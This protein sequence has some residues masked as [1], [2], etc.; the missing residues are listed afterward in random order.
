VATLDLVDLDIRFERSGRGHKAVVV[1][2]PMGDGLEVPFRRPINDQDLELFILRMSR[3]DA[4]RRTL[5]LPPAARAKELG[6]RLF[7]A[8]FHDDLLVCLRD[9]L[10]ETAREDRG[11]RIR[12]RLGAT[13]E[14]S[15]LPWEYL[16]DR[17]SNRF[18]CLSDRTPVV[19]Y[20]EVLEPVRPLLVE[21]PLRVLV[22]V[23]S[24]ND[25]PALDV[26]QEWANVKEALRELEGAERIQ[27]ERLPDATLGTLRRQLRRGSYQALHFIGHGGFDDIRG[28]GVLVLTE[29]DG[30]GCLVS[31]ER[32]GIDLHDETSMRLVVL[33]ACEGARSDAA[34]P[35]SGVAQSLVRQGI[36]AVVAMQFE[37]SDAAAI[38]FAHGFYGALADGM[39]VDASMGQARKDIYDISAFEWATPVL[40][41]RAS[42]GQIFELAREVSPEAGE[43]RAGRAGP[44]RA[45]SA[46]PA[47]STDEEQIPTEDEEQALAASIRFARTKDGVDIAYCVKG[48]GPPLVFV[49]GW[50]THLELSMTNPAFRAFMDRLSKRHQVVR[51]DNRG[52]GLSTREVSRFDLEALTDDIEAVIDDLH[53]VQGVVLWG[54][55]FGG[56]IA[57]RLIA[58]RPE[59]VDRL[60]LDGTFARG[61]NLGTVEERDSFLGMFAVGERQADV[62]FAV[63]SYLTDPDPGTQH[64]TIERLKQSID[65]HAARAL[66]SLLFEIDVESSLS[67]I[68]VPTLV[69]H[70]RSSRAVPFE[71]GLRLAALIPESRF[72]GLDG[73]SHN[74][75]EENPEAALAVIEEFLDSR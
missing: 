61:A 49:R 16:Y 8:L 9:S 15:N 69:L 50:I 17:Q 41:L 46:E 75:W 58:R 30:I 3:A 52:N 38:A 24:P 63:L 40:Y 27:L 35:F 70:R 36:P 55:S 2:S 5:N 44:E 4:V 37:I 26:E 73:T 21:G 57:I 48:S 59:V 39:P 68:T 65:L 66:Y 10:H 11:L 74:P 45:V 51:I 18:L 25:Y 23:S 71:L 20:P 34:D 33:N 67:L 60:I 47:A 14:L 28:E 12:L 1:S 32:L 42:D 13:P 29:S 22:I 64:V 31:G 6:H 72:V 19:R 53:I 7:D 56:P 62:V 43:G 54:S